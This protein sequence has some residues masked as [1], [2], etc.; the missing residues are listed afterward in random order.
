MSDCLLAQQLSIRI[1]ESINDNLQCRSKTIDFVNGAVIVSAKWQLIN[2]IR[3]EL[4][5]SN[6]SFEK[7]FRY[8]Q[9]LFSDDIAEKD[10]C[11]IS[12]QLWFNIRLQPLIHQDLEKFF[13]KFPLI[14]KRSKLKV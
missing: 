14:E 5:E 11:Y 2:W 7:L 10:V 6:N 1:L 3:I 9:I 8:A 13:H 4:I 12:P